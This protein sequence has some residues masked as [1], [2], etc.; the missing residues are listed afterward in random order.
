M[1]LVVEQPAA[2][3]V[4]KVYED[5]TQDQTPPLFLTFISSLLKLVKEHWDKPS[6]SYRIPR[7]VKNVYK[8]HG[9]STEF[10][11]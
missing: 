4:D 3:E 11:S 10:L 7:R 1:G 8:M 5:I 2:E 9:S 6:T